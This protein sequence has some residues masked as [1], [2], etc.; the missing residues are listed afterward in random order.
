LNSGL[1]TRLC[2]ILLLP[3]FDCTPCFGVLQTGGSSWRAEARLV[4]PQA[5]PSLVDIRRYDHNM[6]TALCGPNLTLGAQK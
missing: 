6:Q 1:N 2:A 4:K 5:S 3:L